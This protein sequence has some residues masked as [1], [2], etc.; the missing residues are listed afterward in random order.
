[1]TVPGMPSGWV[2]VRIDDP[3]NG[4]YKLISVTRDSDSKEML[5]PQNAW[6]TNRTM[7][8]PG[9]PVSIEKYFHL[10][11]FDGTGTYTLT[12]QAGDTEKPVVQNLGADDITDSD[13]PSNN[14]IAITFA[15]N[16]AV[17]VSSLDA[18]D[19][20]VIG[21]FGNELPAVTFV[22]IDA[23]SDGSPRTATYNVAWPS[24]PG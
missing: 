1:M 11:D 10:L 20:T 9:K 8:P 22:G 3:A 5:V 19:I 18:Q 12:Y 14:N 4:E 21:P 24:G 6:T 23:A 16:V 2:Y 15:D 17:D 7:R 13:G